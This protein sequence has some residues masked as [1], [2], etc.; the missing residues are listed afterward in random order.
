MSDR[1]ASRDG[2]DERTAVRVSTAG[3]DR[4]GE[5]G[6]DSGHGHGW[7]VGDRGV[8]GKKTI[9]G[10]RDSR[11]AMCGVND[12]AAAIRDPTI[13]EVAWEMGFGACRVLQ[14]WEAEG[15]P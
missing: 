4:D 10:A 15:P 12:T 3:V 6:R 8:R 2:Q 5:Q 14:S 1:V 11:G 13:V 9:P 7:R